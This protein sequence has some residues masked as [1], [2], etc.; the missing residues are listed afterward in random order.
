MISSLFNKIVITW[1]GNIFQI[2]P[3]V[4]TTSLHNFYTVFEHQ[5]NCHIWRLKK[6]FQ[7]FLQHIV[8]NSFSFSNNK[9]DNIRLQTI[10]LYFELAKDLNYLR[11]IA[12]KTKK[13]LLSFSWSKALSAKEKII[14]V[15]L[16]E[17]EERH[18]KLKK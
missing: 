4:N 2:L 5:L 13:E 7:F 12:L 18:W 8:E 9:L 3:I 15:L 6:Q 16:L 1:H 10:E 14:S 11:F 17:F